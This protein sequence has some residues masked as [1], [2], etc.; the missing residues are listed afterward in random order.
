MTARPVAALL[1]AFAAMHAQAATLAPRRIVTLAPACAEIVAGL[2]LESAIVG[3]T[4]YTDWPAR[5]KSL[6][7]VGSYVKINVEA[8][9]ALRPDL[10]VATDDG[11]PPAA[12]Q[13]LQRV[14]LRV[15]TLRLRDVAQ[16]EQSI[17]SLGALT[18]RDAAARR[19][20]EEMKRV[21]ACVAARTRHVPHPR[22][23]FAYELD[24]VISAGRGTFTDQLL[25]LAGADSITR[26]VAQSYPHLGLESVV[27]RA[28][29]VLVVSSMNPV[30]EARQVQQALAKWPP[31]PAVRTHRV[32]LIDS[33]NLDRPSQRVVYGL[34]LLA[35]TIHPA[36]F[37]HGECEAALP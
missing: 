25:A 7:N 19:A 13:R 34:T 22:V 31:V 4:D 14:G 8:V 36:L 30:A 23:L 29:E 16:I 24:P 17:L 37:A 12:L 32:H 26:D 9:L 10:V 28:P 21:T 20:V 33:T 3:V 11:N 1:L 27:A 2:G 35:R 5:M 18:G 6:P 15:V